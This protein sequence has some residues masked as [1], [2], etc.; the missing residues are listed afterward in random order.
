MNKIYCLPAHCYKNESVHEYSK[1]LDRM[2]K[3]SFVRR[4]FPLLC[5]ALLLL[6]V[7]RS[8]IAGQVTMP[9]RP[10]VTDLKLNLNR[11][12][13]IHLNNSEEEVRSAAL[14]QGL[15]RTLTAL[16][17]SLIMGFSEVTEETPL[18]AS[19]V[20]LFLEIQKKVLAT[21][22]R[23]KF[24][25]TL[26][27]SN[28]LAAAALLAKLQEIT[29]KLKPDIINMALSPNNEVVAPAALA[30]GI[31][32]AHLHGELVTYEGPANMIPDGVDG[33]VMKGINGEIRRDE[34]NNFKA[35]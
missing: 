13:E 14:L 19:Q 32:Y 27:A 3:N 15:E 35:S 28:Y 10:H 30:R 34:I 8:L 21:N 25:V 5:S 1:H 4:C 17:P 16:Q 22:P 23:C 2:K 31:E 7:D 24:S 9:L 33:F 11:V 26:H 6:G 29:V 18:S 12:L 20:A